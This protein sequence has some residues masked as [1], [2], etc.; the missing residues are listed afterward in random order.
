[1]WYIIGE[2]FP[3]NSGYNIASQSPLGA[4]GVAPVFLCGELGVMF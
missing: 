1:M 4:G 2:I 3:R